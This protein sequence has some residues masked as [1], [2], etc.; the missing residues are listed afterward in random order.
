MKTKSIFALLILIFVSS[1]YSAIGQK[2]NFSGEWK[3]NKEKTVLA[4]DQLFL[5]AVSIQLKG[6]SLLTTRVYANDYGEE[7]P[8]VENLTL[9]GKE[10]KIVIYDMPRTSKASRSNS[11][12]SIIIESKTT[13]YG[14]SGEEDMIAKET[15]KVDSNG[16]TLIIDYTNSIA[17]N[18]MKGISYYD[19]VK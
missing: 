10:C 3:L 5:S 14:D 18:E 9:N 7:Y 12:G 17:G 6:D 16:N 13:F 11:D 19:K 2:A 4:S 15:W 8:F 1:T